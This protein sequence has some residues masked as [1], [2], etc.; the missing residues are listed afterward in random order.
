MA[1]D[2]GLP[3]E[4]LRTYLRELGPEARAMLI[5]ALERGALGGEELPGAELILQELRNA[6]AAAD[7]APADVGDPQR[8]FFQP[9]APFVVDDKPERRHRGRISQS[10][11]EPIWLWLTRDLVAVEAKAYSDQVGRLLQ[12]GDRGAADQLV[13]AF[14]DRALQRIEAALVAVNHDDK[15]QRRLAAQI[16]IP[17]AIDE[18]REIANVMKLRDALAVIASRLP[19]TIKSL[20][21]EALDAVKGLLD[22]PVARHRDIFVYAVLLVRS[23]LGTPWQLIR[24]ATK[25]AASDEA[26]RVAE[27]PFAVAVTIVL[28]EVE[29]LVA[30][31]RVELKSGQAAAV[32]ALLKEIHDS[33]RALRTELDLSVD[34]P[35]ARQLTQVRS[36]VSEMLKAAIDTAPGRVRRLL[37]QRARREISANSALDSIDVD[38]TEAMIE[39]VSVCRNYASELAINEVTLRVHS[40]LQSYLDTGMNPLL[41]ALRHAGDVDR[42]FRQ[43]Q[44]DAA[45]RFSGK[46]FGPSYA[47][48]FAKAAEVAAQGERKAAKV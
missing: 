9:L 23:R 18:L 6:T 44:V 33:A 14:Q 48:L 30:R 25:A 13:R 36:D 35:W 41:D 39:L 19:M 12:A 20:A 15:A 34:S 29:R 3:V 21:D 8:L 11:I 28:G 42:K 38:D 27:T 4:R 40:E 46:I 31:L 10:A 45:V 7:A 16:G 47:S 17:R 5:A 24:L 2:N 32:T 1:N 26:G 43:S 22:S 37:G